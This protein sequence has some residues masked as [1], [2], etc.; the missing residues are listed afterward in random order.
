MQ[1]VKQYQIEELFKVCD[2]LNLW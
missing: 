1:H 2:Q